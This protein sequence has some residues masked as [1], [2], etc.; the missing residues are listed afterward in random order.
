MYSNVKQLYVYIHPLGLEPPSCLSRFQ[1]SRSSQNTQLSSLCYTAAANP[2]FYIYCMVVYVCVLV[3]QS[4]PTLCNPMYCSPTDASV[5]GFSRQE[6]GVGCYFLLQGIFPTQESNLGLLYC[7][8]ILYSL[9]HQICQ[10]Y[11]L[12]SSHPL[13][14]VLILNWQ[15]VKFKY[16]LKKLHFILSSPTFCIFM[17]YFICSCPPLNCLFYWFYNYCLL[18][19]YLL[20]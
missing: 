18:I 14:P 11:S 15:P 12:I 1:S 20:V 16:M 19:S 2:L 9:I 13:L 3:A 8:Q 7:R 4:C 17:S 5:H 6:Y 10:C